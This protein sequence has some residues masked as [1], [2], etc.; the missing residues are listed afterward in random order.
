VGRTGKVVLEFRLNFLGRV[1]DLKVADTTGDDILAYLCQKAI[2]ESEPFSSWPP[3][4]RKQ[5]K[6]DYRS[7]RFTF[8]F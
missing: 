2:Q 1:S 8:Y 7:M 5:V 6:S 4:L 3:E